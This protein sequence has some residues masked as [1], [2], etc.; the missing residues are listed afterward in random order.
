MDFN[1]LSYDIGML[2]QDF[3][4]SNTDPF[5]FESYAV[6]TNTVER[7]IFSYDRDLR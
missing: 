5:T 1:R 6:N 2:A 7:Y 4:V 3:A